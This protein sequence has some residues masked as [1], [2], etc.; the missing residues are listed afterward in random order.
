VNEEM[1]AA[2]AQL[3]AFAE[4]NAASLSDEAKVSFADFLGSV[5]QRFGGRGAAPPD[6]PI[7]T[8]GESVPDSTRLLW[9]ASGG[10]PDV[11]VRFLQ[12][13]PDAN[14]NQLARDP[15]RL[16]Q[17]IRQLTQEIPGGLPTSREGIP[18]AWLPSSN[19]WGFKYDPRSKKL[20]VK[21]N[22]KNVRGTGPVYEYDDVPPEIAQI[23]AQGSVSARTNGRNRHGRWWISKNPSLGASHYALIREGG[24]AYRRISG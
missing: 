1:R 9:V 23:F 11:F 10:N 8:I 21:F 7:P 2:L 24:Y 12:S 20:R 13:Y 18:S 16:Q 22:G 17:I 3:V 14:L 15:Q 6:A 19:I 5:M 4:A